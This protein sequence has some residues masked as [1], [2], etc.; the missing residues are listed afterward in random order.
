MFRLLKINLK[1]IFLFCDILKGFFIWII[2]RLSFQTV[3]IITSM[4]E[5]NSSIQR[6]TNRW[7]S[8]SLKIKFVTFEKVKL[9]FEIKVD[10]FV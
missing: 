1:H 9:N 3:K 7:P 5:I 6:V 10:F 2:K 4:G 8:Q